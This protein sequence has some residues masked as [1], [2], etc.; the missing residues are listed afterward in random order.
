[1][2]SRT[3]NGDV[4]ALIAVP[5]VGPALMESVASSPGPPDERLGSFVRRTGDEGG[6]ATATD[7]WY[8]VDALRSGSPSGESSELAMNTARLMAR[9]RDAQYLRCYLWCG[10]P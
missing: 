9:P 1:M 10:T 7:V 5:G 4:Q 2:V 8:F 3:Y 6:H